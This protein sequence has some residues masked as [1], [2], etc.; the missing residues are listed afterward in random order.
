MGTYTDEPIQ[1]VK[2]GENLV[3]SKEYKILRG[4][5]LWKKRVFT[6]CLGVDIHITTDEEI[7]DVYVNGNK[8]LHQESK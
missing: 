3:H 1:I 7:R 2:K 5:I 8:Y 4:L 6:E